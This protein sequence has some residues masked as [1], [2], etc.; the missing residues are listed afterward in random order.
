MRA[1]SSSA[2]SKPRNEAEERAAG[3]YRRRAYRIL[4]TNRWIAGY[5]LDI[6]A[7]RGRT[8][9]FCEVKSKMGTG[10]GDPLE[11][12][13]PEKVRRIRRSAEAWLA[14]NPAYLGWAVRF[15]VVAIRGAEL[16]CLRNAF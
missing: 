9:V 8:V 2:Q 7:R 4:E 5:E 12:V 14:S 3:W 16:E 6:V 15:D 1:V 11:M 13:T 10:F